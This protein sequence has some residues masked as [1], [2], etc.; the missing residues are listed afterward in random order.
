MGASEDEM[1]GWHSR[2][3]G[4]EFEEA[5]G[6]GDGQGSLICCTPGGHKESDTIK[7]LNNEEWPCKKRSG[8]KHSLRD[9]H[10]G[11]RGAD[12]SLQARRGG[13][14]HT[15]I[16]D[17]Q[18]LEP[19]GKDVCCL[20][21]PPSLW[22][23]LGQLERTKAEAVLPTLGERHAGAGDHSPALGTSPLITPRPADLGALSKLR[24]GVN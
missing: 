1:V 20:R 9:N 13:P 5:P 12:G 17:F 21:A 16:T 6:D 10:V 11:T 3:N 4:H 7:R 18:P 8:C 24:G 23:L 14:A 22:A 2:H 15:W 19:G